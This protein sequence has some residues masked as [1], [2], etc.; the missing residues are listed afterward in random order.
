MD[1]SRGCHELHPLPPAAE[2]HGHMGAAVGGEQGKG[3]PLEM[4]E[5]KT[6]AAPSYGAEKCQTPT[7]SKID[8]IKIQVA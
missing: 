4:A 8:R 1:K 6:P 5:M 3:T 2:S 7:G